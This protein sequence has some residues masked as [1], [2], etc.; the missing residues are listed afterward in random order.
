MLWFNRNYS[1]NVVNQH[2]PTMIKLNPGP[3][4]VGPFDRKSQKLCSG[5]QRKAPFKR[6]VQCS[7][8]QVT[9]NK[10]RIPKAEGSSLYLISP[11]LNNFSQ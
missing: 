6:H 8:S 7:S 10:S 9:I 1:V 3:S 5:K 11:D 4:H 2:H